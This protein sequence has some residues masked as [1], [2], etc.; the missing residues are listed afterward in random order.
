MNTLIHLHGALGASAQFA[1]LIAELPDYNNLTLDFEGH[2]SQPDGGRAFRIE[3]FAENLRAFITENNL[4]PVRIVGYSMGGYVALWLAAHEPELIHSIVTLGTKFDWSPESAAKEVR[5]LDPDVM[6]EKVPA[7][8]AAL[9]RR[10]TAAGWRTV[11]EKTKDMMLDLG[12]NP[13]I[14][15]DVLLKVACPVCLGRGDYDTM[16]S[17][18]ETL[19]VFKHIPNA[20]MYMLPATP[21]PI[22][23][24]NAVLWAAVIRTWDNTPHH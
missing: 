2:G 24:V 13:R 11:L 17:Y 12:A 21:H 19:P 6:L 10:H 14:T 1:P 5:F 16:V 3:H 4:A 9:E 18:D 23:K 8:A 7:F 22:E 15:P 20:Q